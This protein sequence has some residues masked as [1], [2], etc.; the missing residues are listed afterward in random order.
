MRIEHEIPPEAIGLFGIFREGG[1]V[2]SKSIIPGKLTTHQWEGHI[3]KNIWVVEMNLD[4][5]V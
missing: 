4:G 2:F 3:S 1:T 5:F